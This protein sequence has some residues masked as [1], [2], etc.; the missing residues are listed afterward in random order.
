MLVRTM[1]IRYSTGFAVFILVAAA[2]VLGTSF[3]TGVSI[4]TFTGALLVA[5]GIGY[6]TR[7]L[8]ELTDRELTILPLFGPMKRTYPV[9]GL[10]LVD[11]KIYSGEKRV[12]FPAWCTNSE[13]W[14]ALTERLRGRPN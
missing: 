10:R 5:V 6:L 8:G 9:A 14:G 1:K 7:P 3:V 13:D 2:F 11:G 12:R 4:N